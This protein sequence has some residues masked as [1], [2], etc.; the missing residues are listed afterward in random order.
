MT[1][2]AEAGAAGCSVEDYDPASGTID[3]VD[4]AAGRVA[5]VADAA[6]RLADPLVVTGRAE[7]HLRGVDDLDDT[8]A[9]LRAYRDAGA[10]A[11]Y[12]PGLVDLHHIEKVVDAVEVP[13]ERPRAPRRAERRRAGVGRRAPR[14]DGQ[15]AR[16]GRVRS[17][18]R[19]SGKSCSPREL[20]LRGRGAPRDLLQEAFG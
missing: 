3:D 20:E 11:V 18:R 15:P 13:G 12:A 1:L 2:L 4:V 8:I 6:H 10:D 9:R 14:L 5:A 19:R 16:L 7:N 17:A